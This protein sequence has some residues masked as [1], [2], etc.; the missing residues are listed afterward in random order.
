MRASP[1]RLQATDSGPGTSDGTSSSLGRTPLLVTNTPS[2]YD[3]AARYRVAEEG[4]LVVV[5]L[6]RLDQEDLGPRAGTV[7]VAD[8]LGDHERRLLDRAEVGVELAVRGRGGDLR[9]PAR[10][11]EGPARDED[12]LESLRRF[13]RARD[14][15]GLA[16]LVALVD[17]QLRRCSRGTVGGRREEGAAARVG[18]GHRPAVPNVDGTRGDQLRLPGLAAVLRGEHDSTGRAGAGEVGLCEAPLLAREADL[19]RERRSHGANAA[20]RLA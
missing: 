13:E 15:E 7:A 9:R 16:V 4:E 17:G 5:L 6:R 3:R 19:A 14:M 11:L 20:P 18:I 2:R 12:L 10:G 1:D 8:P